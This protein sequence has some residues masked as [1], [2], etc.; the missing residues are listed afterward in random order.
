MT[1]RFIPENLF[2]G[3]VLDVPT[4]PGI[5]AHGQNLVRGTVVGRVLRAL[6]AASPDP[7]NTG[8]GSIGSL[9]LG[10]KSKVGTYAV[11]CLEAGPPAVFAVHDP[12]GVRLVDAVAGVPYA[13]QLAF[14]ITASGAAFA[15]GDKFTVAVEAGSKEL[16]LATSEGTDGTEAL[17]GILAASVDASSE[18]K[19]CPVY[20]G[21]EFNAAALTFAA[22][23]DADAWEDQA[24]AL[25][26][27][28]RTNIP[29]PDPDDQV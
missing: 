3:G 1:E 6:G 13:G 9:A 28:L 23:D 21:G 2:A 25:N 26:F 24:R 7:G 5:L 10:P 8:E 19:V 16:K 14:T 17:F 29:A 20:L 22:G 18:A 11:E 27:L 4:G 12:D 15:V